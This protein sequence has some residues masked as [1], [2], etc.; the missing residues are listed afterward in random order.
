MTWVRIYTIAVVSIGVFGEPTMAADRDQ[1]GTGE[2]VPSMIA[3]NGSTEPHKVPFATKFAMFLSV[4]EQAYRAQL[5]QDIE[6][7]DDAILSSL[8]IE[9]KAW[10]ENENIR[11]NSEML[12]LCATRYDRDAVTLARES[13]QI[14]TNWHQRR[15]AMF[16][17]ALNSLSSSG[18]RTVE[19]FIRAVVTPGI[20]TAIPN[21]E[22]FAQAE[23]ETFLEGFEITCYLEENGELPADVK[24]SLENYLFQ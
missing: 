15:A 11:Y 16:R 21:T 5:I 17:K 13:E 7:R 19:E 1:D 9:D 2:R 4:Y 12:A 18:K 6:P 20:S 14:A 10:A 22:E 3:V 8:V 23:P 24:E